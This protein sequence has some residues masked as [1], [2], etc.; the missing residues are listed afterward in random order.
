VP[1][2][3]SLQKKAALPWELEKNCREIGTPCKSLSEYFLRLEE[4]DG[5]MSLKTQLKKLR[6]QEKGLTDTD[7]DA[8][9][10]RDDMD[11]DG[12][13][14]NLNK[15][16]NLSPIKSNHIAITN[17]PMAPL[18]ETLPQEA[19]VTE[20]T[21]DP[22]V[23]DPTSPIQEK[24][25]D[26]TSLKINVKPSENENV[27]TLSSK[28]NHEKRCENLII[29]SEKN[30]MNIKTAAE[31]YSQFFK[32]EKD[33]TLNNEGVHNCDPYK[34]FPTVT[35]DTLT[36]TQQS[37][38]DKILNHMRIAWVN[39]SPSPKVFTNHPNKRPRPKT[40]ETKVSP[41]KQKSKTE[42]ITNE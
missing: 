8:Q 13:M 2:A 21:E 37:T 41:D 19:Q 17:P 32:I 12:K 9:D 5:Y 22:P 11:F 25:S 20:L 14:S 7:E 39:K 28:Q 42:K 18:K 40:N 4:E 3:F 10:D 23:V 31:S 26:E 1:I 15:S 35:R 6:A 34:I 16:G 24:K 38:F 30:D 36:S 33:F 29:S 27:D